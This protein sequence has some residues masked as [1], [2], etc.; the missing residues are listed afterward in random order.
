MIHIYFI[1]HVIFNIWYWKICSTV[2]S[3]VVHGLSLFPTNFNGFTVASH[4][5][6]WRPFV[7]VY[8]SCICILLIFDYVPFYLF[9]RC[10][11]IVIA[12]VFSIITEYV[13]FLTE[14]FF[15]FCLTWGCPRPPK[16]PR[17]ILKGR[18]SPQ[19]DLL[20]GYSNEP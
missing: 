13:F 11:G 9:N 10:L 8:R 16:R 12:R 19:I 18:C 7:I 1:L 17:L 3:L 15:F 6:I 20:S 14:L 2:F 4:L 5:C